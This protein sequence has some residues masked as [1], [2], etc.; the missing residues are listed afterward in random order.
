[1]NVNVAIIAGGLA[2]RLR[3]L[4]ETVPKAMVPIH[5]RPF[6]EHQL[7]LLASNGFEEAVVLIG[8]LGEQIRDHFGDGSGFG[9]RLA[10]SED[11]ET[12]R[13]TGG[14]L[15]KALP[16]LTDPFLCIYGDSYLDVPYRPILQDFL[17][18]D[19]RNEGLMTV[20]RNQ[21]LYDTSNVH[22]SDGRIVRYDKKDRTSEM[23]HI[24]WG[25]GIL[26]KVAF[27]PFKARDTFDL[28]EV[29]E[30]LVRRGVLQG[31]E[32]FERFYEVGSFDGIRDLE[33]KI[34]SSQ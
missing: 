31:F 3:P 23:K 19:A 34:G 16:L 18:G 24:D 17:R 4:T 32:V 10:Y 7:E 9:L 13:G 8:F 20:Y 14:A 29:Y 2:T 25:L 27:D 33:E 15:R 22:F 26:R 28:A 30:N 5:G 12:L 6:M 21:G 11:G 1:M